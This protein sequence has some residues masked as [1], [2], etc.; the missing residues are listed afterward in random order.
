[1]KI[2]EV[3]EN[4]EEKTAIFVFGRFNPPT[5]G[6]EALLNAGKTMAASKGAEL[7]VF[8]T[9]SHDNKKNP[10]DFNTKMSF[11]TAFFPDVTF[12]GASEVRTV[13]EALEW[14]E[15]QGYKNVFMVTGSDRVK[16]FN[17]LIKNYIPKF[18]PG[19]NPETAINLET[20]DVI[21]AGKRDPDAE[22]IEGASGTKARKYAMNG[23]ENE[24]VLQIAPTSGPEQLKINL[25]NATRE[26]LGQ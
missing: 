26:G 1:M 12:V 15:K 8:P 25:Y 7:F 6:H 13:F 21:D 22:G 17:N 14:L 9:K 11:L 10:L 24:F 23:Q 2:S 3:F 18:N 4:Q 16:E 5:I 19:T 20:F